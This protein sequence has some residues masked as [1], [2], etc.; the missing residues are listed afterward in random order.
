MGNLVAKI[1]QAWRIDEEVNKAMM[2]F[3]LVNDD[4]Q[5]RTYNVVMQA[6]RSDDL[7]RADMTALFDESELDNIVCND[8][9]IV[10]IPKGYYAFILEDQMPIMVS[11]MSGKVL[12]TEALE[13]WPCALVVRDC[14]AAMMKGW[15]IWHEKHA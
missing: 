1:T 12:L 7:T 8:E 5:M 10:Q 4:N 15:E 14:I 2:S 3:T 11:F 13:D 6:L 9:S